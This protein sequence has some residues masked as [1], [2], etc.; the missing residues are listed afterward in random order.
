VKNFLYI[1]FAIAM[2]GCS[3]G[4][5][6]SEGRDVV[7]PPVSKARNLAITTTDLAAKGGG[8]GGGKSGGPSTPSTN[9]ELGDQVLVGLA[10]GVDAFAFMERYSLLFN[11]KPRRVF[12]RATHG[13]AVKTG[14]MTDAQKAAW[15]ADMDSDSQVR[16][17]EPEGRM[18]QK[19][20]GSRA[21]H[22]HRQ[23]IPKGIKAIGG[24]SS[25]TV[26]GDGTGTVDVDVYVID[27]GVDHP[28]L[29][30][31]ERIDFASLGSDISATDILERYALLER[32]ALLQ[33]FEWGVAPAND[34]IGHGTH[35]A[36]TI[37]AIDDSDDLVGVAPGARIHDFRVLD[38]MGNGDF[39][40][41]IE[42][43]EII[44]ARKE[45]A[46]SVPMVVNLSLGAH[47]G[48]TDFN[49]L[50]EVVAKAIAMG[51]TIV[52]AAGNT[53]VDVSE[54][55]PARVPGVIAVGSVG[56]ENNKWSISA[57]SNTGRGIDIW[58][59]GEGIDSLDPFDLT[60]SNV[61]S[62]TSMAAPHVTGA[63]A[64][65]LSAEPDA[66]PHRVDNFLKQDSNNKVH[67]APNGITDLVVDLDRM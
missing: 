47:V 34:A 50:D 41:V 67:R 8:G 37:A 10:D 3:D 11:A 45:A 35:V 62:G 49:A 61:L 44:I 33:R 52:A 22:D 2:V 32:F 56:L 14:A 60:Q 6:S 46:P 65:L 4:I 38:D 25:S 19:G 58:A 20:G 17:Y 23:S 24:T 55:S 42:A 12:K 54:V 7:A 16:W 36:G 40:A 59:P 9:M 13:I 64:L 51:I 57:F 63:V 5:V 1:C 29:N 31:V 21:M 39:G 27:S 53:G 18:T 48:T 28:D 66:S 30:I 43:L 15:M 26:S